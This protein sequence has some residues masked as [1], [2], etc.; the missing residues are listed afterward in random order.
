MFNFAFPPWVVEAIDKEICEQSKQGISGASD[1]DLLHPEA[2]R[3]DGLEDAL[4]G[5]GVS[6]PRAMCWSIAP[7]RYWMS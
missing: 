7:P 6:I 1:E 3:F 2:V 4:I 5:V